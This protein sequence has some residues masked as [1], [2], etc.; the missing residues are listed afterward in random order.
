MHC[1]ATVGARCCKL[2]SEN[3]ARMPARGFILSPES[4]RRID[5]RRM[6]TVAASAANVWKN[7]S[8]IPLTYGFMQHSTLNKCF[9][10]YRKD[11]CALV[12][13]QRGKRDLRSM[14]L[15]ILDAQSGTAMLPH[16]NLALQSADRPRIYALPCI[17][18]RAM[19]HRVRKHNV[20]S[21]LPRST[22]QS[23]GTVYQR[24]CFVLAR[25]KRQ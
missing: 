24:R 9:G 11:S 21:R 19:V 3:V 15:T 5:R 6:E 10:P 12:T 7:G 13:A 20:R 1:N 23:C 2:H 8:L 17:E 14:Q 18:A 4:Q 25:S 16:T 22:G